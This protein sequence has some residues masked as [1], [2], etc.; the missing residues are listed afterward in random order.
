MLPSDQSHLVKISP[1]PAASVAPAP[2]RA[3]GFGG[4]PMGRGR[5]LPC[6]KVHQRLRSQN[7]EHQQ[8]PEPGLRGPP[9]PSYSEYCREPDRTR[10]TVQADF[11]LRCIRSKILKN[12]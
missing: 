1:A 2:L 8:K 7:Q 4:V 10:M 6:L 9:S 12:G 3:K 5:V 11:L